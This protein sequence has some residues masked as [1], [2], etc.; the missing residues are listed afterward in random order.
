MC[1][2]K[3]HKEKMKEKTKESVHKVMI[4]NFWFQINADESAEKLVMKKPNKLIHPPNDLQ[5]LL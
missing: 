1:K 4:K 5:P 3:E 2:E